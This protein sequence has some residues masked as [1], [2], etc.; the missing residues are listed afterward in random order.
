[1]ISS[2]TQKNKLNSVVINVYLAFLGLFGFSILGQHV[3]LNVLHLPFSFMELYFLPVIWCKRHK[4][5]QAFK[6]MGK[7]NIPKVC[8]Y[9]LLIFGFLYGVIATL[10]V[11]T[12]LAYR[13]ILYLILCYHYVQRTNLNIHPGTILKV[14]I[15]AM[16]GEFVYIIVFSTSSIVSS[17]NCIAI[18]LAIITAFVQQKYWVSIACIAFGCVLSIMTGFRIGIFVVALCG[19]EML[20]YIAFA[21]PKKQKLISYFR[22]F[23]MIGVIVIGMIVVVSNYEI[24]VAKIAKLTGM[25]QFA[26]FRVTERIRGL[27]MGDA[28]ISQ[29]TF[30]LEIM[31][32]QFERF[33]QVLPRGLVGE[34]I[35]EYWMYID[36]PMI[37]LYDLFGSIAS[38]CICLW[39]FKKIMWQV[40]HYKRYRNCPLKI[41]SI[42]MVP[43]LLTVFLI[44][45]TF[46]VAVFQAIETGFLLGILTN[47]RLKQ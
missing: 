26:I 37:Y 8:L 11:N 29:D 41:I 34:A 12:V 40:W 6:N 33:W 42:W 44:N 4:I 28:R 3:V 47:K 5:V 43:V 46:M 21:A 16:I 27:F 36:V 35:G 23:F 25:S 39:L 38:V 14:C 18:A 2:S 32:Y 45:G 10:D 31:K 30:R 13:S 17:T 24:V 19:I 22:R 15:F 20:L 9:L 1:M 7:V